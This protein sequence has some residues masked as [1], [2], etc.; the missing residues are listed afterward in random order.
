MVRMPDMLMKLAS[1]SLVKGMGIE[2]G[3]WLMATK[4]DTHAN[5]PARGRQG[6]ERAKREKSTESQSKRKRLKVKKLFSGSG[7]RGATEG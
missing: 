6:A 1:V 2:R 5:D 4:N 3:N 7:G